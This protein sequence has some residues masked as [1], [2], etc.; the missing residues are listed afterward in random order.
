MHAV[1]KLPNVLLGKEFLL[2]KNHIVFSGPMRIYNLFT[3]R[4]STVEA[5]LTEDF[6]DDDGYIYA[7]L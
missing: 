2:Y 3:S 5:W 6:A 4:L 1:F 7:K